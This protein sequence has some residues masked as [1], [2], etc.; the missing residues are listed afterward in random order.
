M[1]INNVNLSGNLTRDAEITTTPSG[2]V[3]VNFSVAVNERRKDKNTGEWVNVPVY[4]DCVL[5]GNYASAMHPYLAKGSKVALSGRLTF[6]K[7][8]NKEGQTRTKLSV[9]VN[10]L[11]LLNRQEQMP[12]AQAQ[13]QQV[14]QAPVQQVQQ[15]PV[16]QQAPV[17]MYTD[18]PF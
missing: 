12:Q 15:V 18:I 8:Q 5:F 4:V 1:S 16:Q 10:D 14:Q 13:V 6:D 7:W 11:E 3:V 2:V 17:Q 9:I